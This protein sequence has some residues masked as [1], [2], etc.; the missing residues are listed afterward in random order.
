MKQS[1]RIFPPFYLQ[2]SRKLP[3]KW[4]HICH[5]IRV[6]I[7]IP[8]LSPHKFQIFSTCQ[9]LFDWIMS[10]MNQHI[11]HST[12]L[13]NV[14][15]SGWQPKWI[16]KGRSTLVQIVPKIAT[17]CRLSNIKNQNRKFEFYVKNLVKIKGVLRYVA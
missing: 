5:H 16:Y 9:M 6:T 14:S 7:M 17:R 11:I 4:H 3:V 15:H 12:S 13:Q 8:M 10:T 1:F 2:K